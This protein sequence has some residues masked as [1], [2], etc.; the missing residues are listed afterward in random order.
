MIDNSSAV[1]HLQPSPFW[2]DFF[3]QG[4]G[5][6]PTEEA[7]DE[8]MDL[9][10]HEILSWPNEQAHRRI[11]RESQVRRGDDHTTEIIAC[12]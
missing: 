6:W 7:L 9:H 5:P 10:V 4:D 8:W 3:Q 12:L 2:G 1:R 11:V